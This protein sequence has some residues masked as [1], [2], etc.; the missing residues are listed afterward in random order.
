MPL[1]KNWEVLIRCKDCQATYTVDGSDWSLELFG[2][3]DRIIVSRIPQQCLECSNLK[4][5][6]MLCLEPGC[7]EKRAEG[8][9]ICAKHRDEGVPDPLI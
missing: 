2:D 3:R 4:I 9:R 7:Y 8:L 6:D 1:D 5:V